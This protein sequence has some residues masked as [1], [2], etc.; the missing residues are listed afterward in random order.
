MIVVDLDNT[1]YSGVLAEDGSKGIRFESTHRELLQILGELNDRG[2]LICVCTHNDSRDI[3]TLRSV[4]PELGFSLK[5]A[6]LIRATWD[7]KSSEHGS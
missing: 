5:D 7:E 4:W 3:E 2:V 6:A 1:L